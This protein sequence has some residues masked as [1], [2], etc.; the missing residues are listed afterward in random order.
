MALNGI[1]YSNRMV[2]FLDILG[3]ER[4][5]DKSRNDPELVKK[6]A[7][8]LMRSKQIALSTLKAKLTILQ[9]DPNQYVYRAFS[10]TSVISG[11]YVSH[12]DLSFLSMWIMYTQYFLWKEEQ[13]FLR[14]AVVYGDIYHDVDI[15]F[16]PALIDAYYLERNNSKAVWPRV[17]ISESLLNKVEKTDLERDYFEILRRDDNNLVYLDYLKDLFHIIVL[18]ENKKL[19]G[20]REQDFG[21][22]IKLVE[23][24]KRAIL[25]QVNNALKEENKAE[26]KKIIRKYLELSK[27]HN[28][29]I[30]GLRQVINDM[31]KNTNLIKDFYE[32]QMKSAC[33]KE[34][35]LKYM[36]K[37][38][39][40]EHPE[41]SDM[42]NILGT[43]ISR[44][45][46]N[47]QKDDTSMEEAINTICIEA[48]KELLKLG[49]S[50]NE[51]KINLDSLTK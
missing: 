1:K 25:T 39:A 17:L 50:L 8:I 31:M 41:Q 28:S 7:N 21:M 19:T 35:G 36:P 10:D 34:L 30:D 43:V 38:S 9:V 44:I 3:F 33:S 5:V 2:A 29:T 24:H 46:E 20:E 22:P 15:I 42:L 37:Y 32:D 16:G 40:E 47:H 12:D 51:S 48:P 49:Q 26:G 13:I 27:Y 14:G 6:L 45:I 4:I 23:D 11:P 18:G